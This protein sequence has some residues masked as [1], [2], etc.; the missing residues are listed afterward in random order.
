MRGPGMCCPI[1]LDVGVPARA[2]GVQPADVISEFDAAL[3][4]QVVSPREVLLPPHECP[5]VLPR[6]L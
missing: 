5:R 4:S 6:P 3:A 1:G 2:A